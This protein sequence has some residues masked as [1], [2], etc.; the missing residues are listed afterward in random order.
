MAQKKPDLTPEEIARFSTLKAHEMN[1]NLFSTIMECLDQP[2]ELF[3][4]GQIKEL[5][6]SDEHP[7]SQPEAPALH[8]SAVRHSAT[9][10]GMFPGTV[11][12]RLGTP[13]SFI[14]QQFPGTTQ[15]RHSAPSTTHL[16]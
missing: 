7:G 6:D 14:A 1:P 4:I 13:S 16:Q 8:V 5:F 15:R 11:A 9:A 2:G 12:R 10:A 3:C